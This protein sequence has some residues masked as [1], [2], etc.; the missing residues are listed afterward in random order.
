MGQRGE[1]LEAGSARACGSEEEVCAY[2]FASRPRLRFG[3]VDHLQDAEAALRDACGGW[4]RVPVAVGIGIIEDAEAAFRDALRLLERD[5]Q[6]VKRREECIAGALSAAGL[7]PS[8]ATAV[9]QTA[10]A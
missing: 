8:R 7:N 5:K 3:C 2:A 1:R 4:R 10:E 6:V 9:A